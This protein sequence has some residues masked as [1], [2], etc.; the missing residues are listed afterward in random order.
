MDVG[1]SAK[2]WHVGVLLL[3]LG[4]SVVSLLKTL[5]HG[6]LSGGHLGLNF[7]DGFNVTIVF[8]LL[9][10]FGWDSWL[11][12]K[13]LLFHLNFLLNGSLASDQHLLELSGLG[14][15]FSNGL[16]VLTVAVDGWIFTLFLLEF[17]LLL[18]SDFGEFCLLFHGV[19]FC[20]WF[21]LWH[22]SLGSSG[23]SCS[24]V[25]I[26]GR[27]IIEHN[28]VRVAWLGSWGGHL[29]WSLLL[30]LGLGSSLS[31]HLLL[32]FGLSLCL[33]VSL[34]S[35]SCLSSGGSWLFDDLLLLSL[36]GGSGFNLLDLLLFWLSLSLNSLSGGGSLLF[37]WLSALHLLLCLCFSLSLNFGHLLLSKTGC[38]SL[39]SDITCLNCGR[40]VAI[41]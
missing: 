32:G 21:L 17:R 36:L 25:D 6:S 24:L 29:L 41:G 12:G 1:Q 14:L 10:W 34:T 11:S 5:V 39:R 18:S 7:L 15:G 19:H 9:N 37:L 33:D 22:K 23:N 31:L 20:P 3:H 35:R 26:V 27:G 38:G 16:D 28:G 30:L 4:N 8:L 40:L 2:V 13:L